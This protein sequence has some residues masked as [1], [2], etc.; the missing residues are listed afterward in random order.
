MAVRFALCNEVFQGW[1]LEDAFAFIR[2]VGYEGVEIAPFTL[3]ESADQV[4]PEERR[5]LRQWANRLGL[6]IVG[7]HWLLVSPPGLHLTTPDDAVRQRTQDYFRHLLHLCADLG[8]RIM[9]VGSPKQRSLVEGDTYEAA[10]ERAKR[11]FA[12][13]LPLAERLGV[14]LCIEALPNET[15]F[16]PTLE[17]ALRFVREVNH[18]NLQTMVDVKSA[19]AEGLPLDEAVR[20]VAPHL[21]HVHA[22]DANR[23][24]PGMGDT[25][26]RPLARALREIGYDGYVSVEVFDF[27]P[28]PERIAKESLAYLRKIFAEG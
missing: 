18:P 13:L 15:N 28:G 23:L 19:V 24:G 3:A 5:R 27:S 2:E 26:L 25:D 1:R 8:G 12:D 6:E 22:N 17:E 14:T 16:I 21:R 11:F 7:L 20:K 9:V 10:W 4:S